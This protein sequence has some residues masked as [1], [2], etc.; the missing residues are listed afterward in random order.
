M[1]PFYILNSNKSK[2]RKGKDTDYQHGDFTPVTF[3]SDLTYKMERLF[4]GAKVFR[5]FKAGVK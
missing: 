4:Q 2:I 3:I 1:F 5:C